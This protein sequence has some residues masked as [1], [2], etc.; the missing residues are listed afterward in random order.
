MGRLD[1][2]ANHF[3]RWAKPPQMKRLVAKL[4]SLGYEV[5]IKPHAA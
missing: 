3:E 5:E 1:L 4:Q 2:G